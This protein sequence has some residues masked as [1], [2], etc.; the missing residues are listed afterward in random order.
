V[1]KDEF[2]WGE[3]GGKYGG[4]RNACRFSVAEQKQRGIFEGLRLNEGIVLKRILK[5]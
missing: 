2:G 3:A 4:K 1:E 5:K